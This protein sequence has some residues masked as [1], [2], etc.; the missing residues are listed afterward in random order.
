MRSLIVS[1]LLLTAAAPAHA[2]NQ[3]DHQSIALAACSEAGL[4]LTFC[5]SVARAAYDV[6]AESWSEPSAHA[7]IADRGDACAAADQTEARLET[8]GA[9]IRASL[10]RATASDV[11]SAL[12]D[13]AHDLGRAL[14]TIQDDCAHS[15]MPNAQHAA[16]T[17][18]DLCNGTQSSPDIQ[19]EALACA[20]RESEVALRAFVLAVTDAG[21][22]PDAL[23]AADATDWTRYPALGDVCDFIDSAVAWDGVDRRWNNDVVL[24][25]LASA[26]RGALAGHPPAGTLCPGG[27]GDIARAPSAIAAVDKRPTCA[28]TDAFCLGAD[29]TRTDLM[30][31]FYNV[32]GVRPL[33]TDVVH[34]AGDAVTTVEGCSVTGGP[35]GADSL[36]AAVLALLLATRARRRARPR[37]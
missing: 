14:H 11:G 13:T 5:L 37:A 31:P 18:S 34:A 29:V 33:V 15:G 25:A 12:G 17:D 10:A 28:V 35:R 19:P 9:R 7:Q 36:V 16:L 32:D 26:F 23:A 22:A 21:L 4:P 30:P 20:A 1:L 27:P 3:P 2:L 24:P 6:D 8:L